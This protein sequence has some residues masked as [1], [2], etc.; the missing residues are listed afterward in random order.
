MGRWPRIGHDPFAC[1]GVGFL[2]LIMWISSMQE[3]RRIERMAVAIGDQ[4]DCC[5][6]LKFVVIN[7]MALG[8]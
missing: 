5:M 7:L 4:F 3:K 6:G 1:G 8:L 2:G